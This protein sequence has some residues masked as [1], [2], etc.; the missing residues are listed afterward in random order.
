VETLAEMEDKNAG[1][2]RVMNFETRRIITQENKK[3]IVVVDW[4]PVEQSD[5]DILNMRKWMESLV[6]SKPESNVAA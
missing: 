3:E 5:D 1:Y 6:V 2:G 4:S